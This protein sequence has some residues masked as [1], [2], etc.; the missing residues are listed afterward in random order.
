MVFA[1]CLISLTIN[2]FCKYITTVKKHLNHLLF[3]SI[4]T[5]LIAAAGVL[6][7]S[8][9]TNTDQNSGKL[10]ESTRNLDLDDNRNES[11]LDTLK[12]FQDACYEYVKTEDDCKG[13]STK[14]LLT[15]T[16]MKVEKDNGL[17]EPIDQGSIKKLKP[18][19][20]INLMIER[21]KVERNQSSSDISYFVTVESF[22]TQVQKTDFSDFRIIQPSEKKPGLSLKQLEIIQTK[23][24]E[25]L[26]QKACSKT[27]NPS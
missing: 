7:F 20:S 21:F 10:A 23:M 24:A 6:A 22:N 11:A 16:V 15:K 14:D 18:N 17:F 8:G 3:F 9:F 27:V 26:V 4:T 1:V 25:E 19:T 13:N 5:C 12:V 2:Y